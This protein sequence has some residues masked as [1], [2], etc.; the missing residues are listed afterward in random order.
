MANLHSRYIHGNLVFYDGANRQRI[1]DA[2]GPGVTVFDALKSP[3]IPVDDTTGLPTGYTVTVVDGGSD[4]AD[5]FS[6]ADGKLVIVTN[7]ADN[8]G[9][10][11]QLAGS[12]AYAVNAATKYV[13]FGI[14]LKIDEATQSDIL[15]GLCITD[16]DLLGGMTDGIYFECL[17]GATAINFVLEKNSTETTSASAVGT[18]ADATD[19]VL[20]FVF[21]GTYVDAWVN[22]V[23][24]TRLATTNLPN[25]EWLT[26][27]VHV[28]TGTT[29][30]ATLTIN[31]MRAV[32]IDGSK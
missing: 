13:Y 18:L 19:V 30:A 24:Q 28:L 3:V 4:G 11:V 2:I 26:P 20:E 21:D 31:W 5:A 12:E 6:I 25:D 8:D 15:A 10:N 16:T 29:A 27:S 23:Q 1:V 9:S 17:D 22:G 32:M 14:S 7:D